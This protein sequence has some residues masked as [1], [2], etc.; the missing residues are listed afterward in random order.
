MVLKGHHDTRHNDIQQN[1][2][3]QDIYHNNTQHNA[4]HSYAECWLCSVSFM[5]SV[6][7]ASDFFL[8]NFQTVG[9][10]IYALEGLECQG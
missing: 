2:T 7:H 8:W 6:A 5:L 10:Y 1:D 4:E 9:L 3:Q